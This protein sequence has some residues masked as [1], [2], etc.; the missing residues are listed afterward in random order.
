[1]VP[2]AAIVLDDL[3]YSA[4]AGAAGGRFHWEAPHSV[5]AG[6]GAREA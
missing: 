2:A 3:F 5:R 4:A 1:M 6:F